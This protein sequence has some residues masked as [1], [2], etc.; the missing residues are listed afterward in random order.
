VAEAL[1]EDARRLEPGL[2]VVS[3]KGYSHFSWTPEPGHL[4]WMVV[5]PLTYMNLS[6]E[7]VAPLCRY[8]RIPPDRVVAVHDDLDLEL[9]RL[10]FKLS[11][12]TAGHKGL[13]SLVRMLGTQDF[14]RL[15]LGIGRP[16]NM[17]GADYVLARFAPW[18]K[19]AVARVVEE[20]V[21][22]LRLFATRG[23]EAAMQRCHPFD[24]APPGI[25]DP[26]MD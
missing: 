3:R 22:G 2:R 9:G 1:L 24:A 7:A 23:L 15:R 18:E 13:K 11:G 4:P 6:G 20:A 5:T 26:G 8:H 19:D 21:E 10:K 14:H 12:G 16:R 17:D 25:P